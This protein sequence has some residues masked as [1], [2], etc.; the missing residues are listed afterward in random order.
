MLDAGDAAGTA[1]L[2]A[3]A[4]AATGCAEGGVPA[5]LGPCSRCCGGDGSH[6]LASA[7]SKLHTP[8]GF[9]RPQMNQP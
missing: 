6:P 3:D 1:P 8:V 7:V 2:G 4:E 9:F 5:G